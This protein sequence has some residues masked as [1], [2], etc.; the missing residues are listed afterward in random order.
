[1]IGLNKRAASLYNNRDGPKHGDEFRPGLSF[2][3]KTRQAYS[4]EMATRRSLWAPLPADP[5]PCYV[6]NGTSAFMVNGL[7]AAINHRGACDPARRISDG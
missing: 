1:M 7:V 2:L 3:M 6:S 4:T 5:N